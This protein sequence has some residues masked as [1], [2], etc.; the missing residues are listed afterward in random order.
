MPELRPAQKMA[1][2][3]VASDSSLLLADVGAGKTATALQALRI[4]KLKFGRKRTLLLSTVRVCKIVW[5]DEIKIWTPEFSYDHVAGKTLKQRCKIIEDTTLDIVGVNVDNLIWLTE[6]YGP[7]LAEL[8]DQLVIDESSKIHNPRS[9]S[10]KALKPYLVAFEWRL[11]MTG[12][13]RSN[14]LYT[15]W[16]NAYLADLGKSLGQFFDGFLQNFF[17]PVDSHGHV[18]WRPKH[19]AEKQIYQRLQNVVHRMPF[20]W[21]KPMEIFYYIECDPTVRKIF[22][23]VDKALK[24]EFEEVIIDGIT[25]TR[26][27]KRV[28]SKFLQLSSGFIYDD[29]GNT[30]HLHSAKLQALSEIIDEANG[31]PVMVIYQFDHERDAILDYFPQA[32]IIS[33]DD[34][35][36]AW[37]SRQI[38]VGLIHPNSCGYGLNAQFSGCD[39]QVWFSPIEDAEK[40]TQVVGRINRPGNDKHVRVIRLVMRNTYDKACFLVVEARQRGEEATLEMFE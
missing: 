25:Y 39:L 16:G 28:K 35:L 8:F 20:E 26:N 32:K 33:T 27:G 38:E 6:T 9:K 30:V 24:E 23:E 7:R 29:E 37:N 19:D 12:T 15:I 34:A 21:H 1:V 18:K 31:E 3:I 11:P 14:F 2:P 4:R 10:F 40:Y 36:K 5:P 17:F 13:P 22:N